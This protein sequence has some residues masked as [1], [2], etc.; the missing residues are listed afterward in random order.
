MVQVVQCL[1]ASWSPEFNPQYRRGRG[2]ECSK[3]KDNCAEDPKVPWTRLKP[4]GF[5]G[6]FLDPLRKKMFK[7]F[8]PKTPNRYDIQMGALS[9][10]SPTSEPPEE[11]KW[12]IFK[13]YRKDAKGRQVKS[14]PTLSGEYRRNSRLGGTERDTGEEKLRMMTGR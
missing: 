5:K 11:W 4:A 7:P 12:A 10:S 9:S 8:S 14:S 2:K 3:T 6:Q 13:M 1:L